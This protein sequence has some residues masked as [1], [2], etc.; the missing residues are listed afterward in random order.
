MHQGFDLRVVEAPVPCPDD[1][2]EGDGHAGCL[3]RIHQQHTLPIRHERI[4]VAVDDQKRRRLGGHVGHGVGACHL[5][6]ALLDRAADQLRLGRVR[7][8]MN[9]AV[10]QPLGVHLQEVGRPEEIEHRLDAARLIEVL[11]HLKVAFVADRAQHRRQVTTRRLAPGREAQRI[12]PIDMGTSLYPVRISIE[13]AALRGGCGGVCSTTPAGLLLD[14][15]NRCFANNNV[16]NIVDNICDNLLL[17]Q[18]VQPLP[19]QQ[20]T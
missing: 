17:R 8:I 10:R 16:D 7:H 5:G 1:G 12:E 4:A 19:Q 3:Q 13:Q 6:G 11:A 2:V 20:L 18:V 15:H 9:L 14:L